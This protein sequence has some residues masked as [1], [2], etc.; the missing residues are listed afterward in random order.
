MREVAG[1]CVVTHRHPNKF[2][3]QKCDAA[4]TNSE[5]AFALAALNH[6]T[7][8]QLKKR[9][10]LTYGFVPTSSLPIILAS[11]TKKGAG[12]QIIVKA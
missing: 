11:P 9:R 5:R 7:I 12:S 8:W 10:F 2:I 4:F 3:D 6:L 1:H